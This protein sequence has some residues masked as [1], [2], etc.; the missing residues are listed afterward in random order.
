MRYSKTYDLFTDYGQFWLHDVGTDVSQVAQ[1]WVGESGARMLAA[2]PDIVCIGTIRNSKAPVTIEVTE[3]EPPSTPSDAWDQI[4]ECSLQMPVGR[5]VIHD[6]ILSCDGR[7]ETIAIP[8]GCYR[9]RVYS[10]SLDAQ[11]SA[12][13]GDDHYLVILWPGDEIK[14]RVLKKWQRKG[15]DPRA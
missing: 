12:L 2:A 4:V 13:E 5:L 15:L 10:G 11:H 7:H 14:P 9:V 1:L 6:D 8:P 3:K